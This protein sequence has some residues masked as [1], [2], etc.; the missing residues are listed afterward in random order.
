[1]ITEYVTNVYNRSTQK[2]ELGTETIE[3]ASLE[4][5]KDFCNKV[6]EAGGAELLDEL[7]PALPTDATAC[8][9][10]KALNFDSTVGGATSDHKDPSGRPLWAMTPPTEEIAK[11][12]SEALGLPLDYAEAYTRT[13]DERWKGYYDQE[14]KWFATG[15]VGDAP[16]RP[17]TA[18]VLLPVEIGNIARA[19][20]AWWDSRLHCITEEQREKWDA[21]P[22]AKL[23][24]PRWMEQ[25]RDQIAAEHDSDDDEE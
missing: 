14:D 1:M 22:F 25:Y 10:A 6:R 7:L 24:D 13:D 19:Y 15:S 23:V 17:K 20:D 9:I 21:H 18:G 4:E 3:H 8:L 2:Y 5:L 12:I 16:E 11:R